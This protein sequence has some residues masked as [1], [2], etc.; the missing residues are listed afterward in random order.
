VVYR[1]DVADSNGVPPGSLVRVLDE[2]GKF[3]EQR[4]IVFVADRNPYDLA[5]SVPICL[6]WLWSAFVPVSA[7]ARDWFPIP[8]PTASFSAKVIFAGPDCRSL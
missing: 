5:R 1:S 7:T 2:R 4:S 3:L 8:M 6:R